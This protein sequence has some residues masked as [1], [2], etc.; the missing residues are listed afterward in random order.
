MEGIKAFL[1]GIYVP[2]VRGVAHNGDA[3]TGTSN[4]RRIMAICSQNEDLSR[5][6]SRSW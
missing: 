1:T 2:F 3:S 4:V 5:P 6:G